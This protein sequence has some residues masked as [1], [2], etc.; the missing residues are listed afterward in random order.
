MLLKS[1][2]EMIYDL[3]VSTDTQSGK[4]KDRRKSSLDVRTMASRASEGR[5]RRQEETV[6]R[7]DA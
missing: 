6:V 4:H 2:E 3:I 1:C 7:P 5:W